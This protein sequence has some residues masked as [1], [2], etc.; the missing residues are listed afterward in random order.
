MH[1]R[2]ARPSDI[3]ALARVYVETWCAAYRGIL[4]DAYLDSMTLAETETS[5]GRE[6]GGAG[7]VS[8]VAETG[9]GKAAGLITGGIDRRRDRIYGGEIFSLYVRPSYQRRGIGHQ[10]VAHLVAQINRLDIFTLKVQVLEANPCRH[11]YEK[12]NG[13]L[14]ACGRIR[15]ADTDIEACTYGWLDT[16]LIGTTL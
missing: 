13:V 15:F 6:I 2:P 16:D 3:H 12:I 7:V 4:P 5:L 8:L 11:F 9:D 14:L 1:I 10:L